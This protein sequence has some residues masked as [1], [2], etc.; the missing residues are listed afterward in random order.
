MR[1]L[2][3]IRREDKNVW[4]ARVSLVPCDIRELL[5]KGIE[6]Y[7]QPSDIRA[8]REKEFEE[9]GVRIEE[10]LSPC[11]VIFGVKEM[12]AQFFKKGKTYVFFAHVIKGQKYNMPMLGRMMELGCNLIDY[13]RIV[14]ENGRRLV[15]FGRFAG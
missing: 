5:K 13:E 6:F 3:G 1:K 15:F 11:S 12:P 7:I 8:F 9:V 2:C 10:D 14:D 4:E